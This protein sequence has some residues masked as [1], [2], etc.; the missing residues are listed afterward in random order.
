[1]KFV[2][3]NLL[4]ELKNLKK[5]NFYIYEAYFISPGYFYIEYDSFEENVKIG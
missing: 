4:E 3:L 5:I 1:M 2:F